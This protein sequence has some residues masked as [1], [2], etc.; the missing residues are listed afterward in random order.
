M[1]KF[2]L[3]IFETF[4]TLNDDYHHASLT[5]LM[6]VMMKRNKFHSEKKNIIKYF[7]CQKEII[8]KITSFKPINN[9]KIFECAKITPGQ[10]FFFAAE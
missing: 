4:K 3:K 5:I 2:V 6:M 7:E 1:M 10:L 9:V 8:I